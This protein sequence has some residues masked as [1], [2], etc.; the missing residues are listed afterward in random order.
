MNDMNDCRDDDNFYRTLYDSD[1][2]SV[3]VL[4]EKTTKTECN[5]GFTTYDSSHGHCHFCGELSCRGV[6]FK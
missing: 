2:N 1:G 4:K 6:C 3:R 5:S